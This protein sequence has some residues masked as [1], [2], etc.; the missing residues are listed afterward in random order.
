MPEQPSPGV[1]LP[2]SH[3]SPGSTTLSPQMAVGSSAHPPSPHG[4]PVLSG[5][6]ASVKNDEPPSSPGVT[7]AAS[8]FFPASKRE[9]GPPL[10]PPQATAESAI[11]NSVMGSSRGARENI[12]F[13][14]MG[15]CA[16]RPIALQ[17]HKT[18]NFNVTRLIRRQ[19]KYLRRHIRLRSGRSATCAHIPPALGRR[20]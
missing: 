16:E 11:A 12:V 10:L 19:R 3:I 7:A 1:A 4:P 2:S 5:G 17:S 20:P 15:G 8:S 14:S 6:C 13:P 18:P 9:P